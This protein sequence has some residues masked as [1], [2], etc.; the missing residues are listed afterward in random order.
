[1][2]CKK[3]LKY[4]DIWYNAGIFLL[5][6]AVLS[7]VY[8]RP[9][10]QDLFLYNGDGYTEIARLAFIKEAVQAGEW[11]LWNK[12][13]SAGMPIA[14]NISFGS[15]YLPSILLSFFPFKFYIYSH[16]ILHLTVGAFFFFLLLKQIGCRRVIAAFMAFVYLF[17][18]D[19]G[20]V[21]REHASI[22]ITIVYLPMII[23]WIE[24]YLKDQRFV[25]LG[26]AAASMALQFMGGFVQCVFYSD[27]FA[28]IFLLVGSVVR[29]DLAWKKWLVHA[30][31]WMAMYIGLTAVQ[32][33]PFLELLKENSS[34]AR[35][36][37]T[38]EYFLSLSL[39]PIKLLQ[40]LFPQFFGDI[41]YSIGLH[42]SSG[43][44][45]ELYM[46][47]VV[48][49]VL[50]A[51]IITYRKEKRILAYGTGALLVLSW[52]SMACFPHIARV[53]SKIPFLG[54]TRVQSRALFLFSFLMLLMTAYIGELVARG[55]QCGIFIKRVLKNMKLLFS[56]TVIVLVG[57]L[58]Y[59]V[60]LGGG[61]LACEEVMNGFRSRIY[62][63]LF[64]FLAA[65]AVLAGVVYARDQ[66]RIVKNFLLSI[67]LGINMVGVL[68]Y[69]LTY[70]TT[71][72]EDYLGVNHNQSDFLKK[73]IGNSKVWD[74]AVS[75]EEGLKSILSSNK[76]VA[77]K[78]A[79]INSY[80]NFTNPRLYMML[81]GVET[82]PLNDSGSLIA[83]LSAETNLRCRNDMLSMLGIKYVMDSGG[84]LNDKF[85]MTDGLEKE[86]VFFTEHVE[87]ELYGEDLY[88]ASY[89]V[90]IQKNKVYKISLEACT[91]SAGTISVDF[92]GN[93]YDDSKQQKE[94]QLTEEWKKYTF[95]F[96]SGENVPE[97]VFIRV[98]GNPMQTKFSV[99]NL[100]IAE[101]RESAGQPYRLASSGE[102]GDIY[103]NLNANDIF[104]FSNTRTLTKELDVY[105]AMGLSLD[106]NSYVEGGRELENSSQNKSI[107]KV[108]FDV[109]RAEAEVFSDEDSF[110]N[111]SQTYYPGWHAYVD[112]E[113][114]KVYAVNGVVMGTYVPKGRHTVCFVFRPFS[115]IIGAMVSIIAAVVLVAVIFL[116]KAESKDTSKGRRNF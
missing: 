22:V 92:Y 31:G 107:A 52:S 19:L 91:D 69:T 45:I 37:D 98:I 68:P 20:G 36:T 104:Y 35:K 55:C 65:S 46:G 44:D 60:A 50:L 16:Y 85:V 82:A 34:F 6:L 26:I 43:M 30:A 47:P 39:H 3:G 83:N 2:T 87:G 56:L 51:G 59:A 27:I 113:E 15:F 11:P 49:A 10:M 95:T 78:T 93:E 84:L 24:R 1:M 110:V 5:L 23:Y 89:D 7:V 21:R 102:D 61:D 12:Y 64:L 32:L 103:E 76:G 81:N 112:G 100:R 97:N 8:A 29:K 71:S 105:K 63:D 70:G 80:T 101:L 88:V 73:N 74:D 14:G 106:K 108:Q 28:G 9:Y 75:I 79:C 13:L 41:N 109:N 94:L 90:N 111:F 54:A 96:L 18:I 17:S 86:E 67:L 38:Y 99:K 25:W 42:Y 58:S 53:I 57:M 48:I 4:P 33:I 66:K 116:G 115:V 62:N 40:M 77:R 72:V 114:Q